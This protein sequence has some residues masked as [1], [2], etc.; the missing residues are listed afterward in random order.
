VS[1]VDVPPLGRTVL[2][3]GG[4]PAADLA[5]PDSGRWS[6]PPGRRTG[7]RTLAS[8]GSSERPAAR[9]AATGVGR[10][11]GPLPGTPLLRSTADGAVLIAEPGLSVHAVAGGS[12]SVP[13][14]G[15]LRLRTDDGLDIG[16]GGV[17]AGDALTDGDRVP[18]GAVLGVLASGP[19][20]RGRLL[21]D[22]RNGAGAPV[23][24][25]GLLVGLPDPGELGYAA[26][27]GGLGVDPDELDRVLGAAEAAAGGEAP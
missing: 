25:A 19:G 10:R 15:A 23:D 17:V 12:V 20:G 7:T 18:A 27:P 24:P 16:Y 8:R 6:A 4:V 22:V 11:F 26:V 1:P 13:A 21:L 2:L 3:G 14:T 5:V 9:V